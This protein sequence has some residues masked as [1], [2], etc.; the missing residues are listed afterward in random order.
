MKTVAI[1]QA[2]LGSTRLPGKVLMDLGGHTVLEWC[3]RACRATAGIDDVVIATSE[4]PADDVIRRFCDG[5]NLPCF[6]GSEV[7]VLSRFFGAAF[8]THADVILRLTGDCPFLDPHV[9]GQVVRLRKDANADYASN[10]DPPGFPDGLDTEIFTFDTLMA[11]HKNAIRPIDR[12]CVT[13]WMMRNPSLKKATL[14]PPWPGM[15]RERWVLDT[16]ADYA[17]CKEIARRVDWVAGPPSYLDILDILDRAP[18]LRAINPGVRNE[19]FFAALQ[20]EPPEV[21]AYYERWGG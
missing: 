3:V 2:R 6:R 16:A 8:H 19:R 7:D 10:V 5:H 14:A 18:H 17:F 1:I 15:D 13:L 21:R 12:D 20:D 4:L 9:I 11:A